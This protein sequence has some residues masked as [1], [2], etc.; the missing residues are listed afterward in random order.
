VN[1]S[2]M[3]AAC[4][5]A[6]WLCWAAAQAAEPESRP[7][8]LMIIVDDMNDWI[9]C[10]GGHPDVQTPNLDRLARRGRLFTNAHCPAPVCNP[11]RVAV[12]TGRAPHRTGIY[13]NAAVWHRELP[14]VVS[15][16]GHFKAHGYRVLGGGKVNHHMPDFNRRDDWDEYFE[17]VFDSHAQ[18]ATQGGDGEQRF[19]WPDGFPLNGLPEVAALGNP[20]ANAREFDW[21]P[22]DVPDAEMGDGRM[23]SWAERI[24]RDP[25][26]EPFLLAA[27]IYRPHLPWYAPRGYFD[28]YPPDGISLPPI[29]AGDVDDLPAAGQAMAADRRGDLDLVRGHGQERELLQ[30]Y[31]ANITFGDALIGRLLDALDAGPARDRTIVVL[32]SDHGWHFGE[33]EHLH[34]F[35]LWERS[36]RVPCLISLPEMPQPGVA[37]PR[38]VG[39]I[40]LFPTLVDLC[41]LPVPAELDGRSLVPLLDDPGQAWGEPVLT[42][43]GRG[44]HALRDERWRLIR[45]ADGGEEFYDHATDPH[46][47]TNLAGRPEQAAT[48]ARL[49]GLLP[50]ADAAP[51]GPKRSG[52]KA[53][54]RAPQAAA[55]GDEP[56]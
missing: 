10:L 55:V 16:P 41:G 45:Y 5:L 35:T 12:L 48:V 53:K 8:V 44:N 7:N 20:P 32:W 51:R 37:T 15:L 19:R 47:W 31:L 33:K 43:H 22:F 39:L 14:D 46:E 54:K 38:P 3:A 52:T 28:M 23:V 42:T 56:R 13:D 26:A 17:Q 24:L 18:R 50:A 6:V 30:A 34:K 25:P 21:G 27:G 29:K 49:R 11:S 4:G 1:C 40:D 36:T 9:G 2:R